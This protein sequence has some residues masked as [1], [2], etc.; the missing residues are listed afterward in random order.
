MKL[1][2]REFYMARHGQTEHNAAG[3]LSR[4]NTQLTDK[5]VA[6]AKAAEPIFNALLN[7]KDLMVYTSELDRAKHTAI[8]M[9]DLPPSELHRESGINERDMGE[10]AGTLLYHDYCKRYVLSESQGR[11]LDQE[12]KGMETIERHAERVS[13]AVRM[14]LDNTPPE[15]VPAFICHEGSIRRLVEAMG[16]NGSSFENAGVYHFEPEGEKSWK[17]SK[18]EIQQGALQ[19]KPLWTV[20]PQTTSRTLAG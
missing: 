3:V 9:V 2:R 10:E 17:I 6:G 15:R 1:P 14:R 13:N 8:M 4:D 20:E 11:T 7:Q 5:G 12:F 18:V 19:E 16:V